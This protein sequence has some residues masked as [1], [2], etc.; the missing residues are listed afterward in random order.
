M[1]KGSLFP[2]RPA[3]YIALILLLPLTSAAQTTPGQFKDGDPLFLTTIKGPG[4]M[5]S[6]IGTLEPIYGVSGKDSTLD[7]RLS[8]LEWS[9]PYRNAI[10]SAED[11]D[12]R[13]L[14][15]QTLYLI[16]DGLGRRVF[17]FNANTS[18]ETW[19]FPPPQSAT[20]PT[21]E[22]YLNKPVD[23]FIYRDIAT[24]YFKV[25]IT[26]QDRNRVI[27]VDKE[28]SKIDWKYGDPLYREG[29]GFNQLR[30]PEDAEK[31]PGTSEYI[32]AD[33]GNNRVIIVDSNTNNILWELG[34]D[35]LKSPVDIQYNNTNNSILITDQGNHRVILVDRTSKSI[36]W[37]FGRTGVADSGAVGL[38]LPTDADLVE[39]TNHVII[40][41]AGNER[42]IEVDQ[43]GR[44][45]WQFHRRLKGLRDVDRIEN[46]RTLTVYENYPARLAYTEA[47]VVSGAYDLGEYHSSVFDSL[48]WKA[49][50]VAG[51]T[52]A[53]FQLRT[54][55]SAFALDGATWFGPNGKD[56][57]YTRSG[58]ALNPVHTGHRWYQFR[59]LLKTKDPLQ[60][61]IIRGVSVVHH[62]YDVYR[63]ESYFFSPIISESAGKLVSQ[64]N[65]LSFKTI[66][67]K[68]VEKRAA[69]DI[70]VRILNAK[71]S[72]ILERFTASKLSESNEITLS[73][74]PALKGIQSIYLVASLSTGNSS[75]TPIMD[76][77]EITWDA[78]PTANSS[79]TFTDR[80]A[81]PKAYYRTTTTLPSTESFVDSVYILLRDPDLEPFRS[82]YRVTVRALGTKDSVKVDLKLLTLGGFFSSKAI[83][84]LINT[85]AVP[86]N[87]IMEAQDRDHL[88]VSYQDSMTAL[89][90][91]QDT[92]LVVKNTTGLMTIENTRK[93]EIAKANFGDTLFV[94]IKNESD[95]NLD[96]DR[97]E[98][99]HVALFDNVTMDREELTL[100]E[101]AS[102][103]RFNSSEFI[104]QTGVPIRHSNNGIRGNGEIETMPG[105]SVAAEY[106]DNLTLTR[107][108]LIPTQ[109]DTSARDSI[110]IFY[111]RKPAGA[112]IGPNPYHADRNGK[113]RLR[114]GFSTDSLAV[115]SIEI[116]NLAGER[117]RTLLPGVDFSFRTENNVSVTNSDLWWDLRN[118]GG[119]E[120][121]SGTYWAKVNAETRGLTSPSRRINYLCKFVIIR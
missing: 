117:V 30:S 19:S 54:A 81:N 14:N 48:F 38:K 36:L 106:V 37:Q 61:A 87:N 46:G 90:A 82:T 20:D 26:D 25:V 8:G 16:T 77:W 28:T 114:V 33:K 23:A 35:V 78:I 67:A 34:S 15:G 101:V 12:S 64:W 105:H 59:A 84:I 89:D 62:Y 4:T 118:D 32:I 45:V 80:N 44:I 17:E 92:I 94:R 74:L 111:G 58:S 95:H 73:S 41:D 56:S 116:F 53:W 10:T 55:E 120:V 29:N 71:N 13:T 49:D 43:T 7:Y 83:P 9:Y 79:I 31:I 24:S 88:V 119:Q 52:S 100:Y 3:L 51:T 65:K 72:Q 66:L 70:E 27:T 22:K 60:T 39:E 85:K 121:S 98:T 99:L 1:K 108:V 50:T 97:Q 42:I 68:E 113:F 6:D 63:T 5:L 11:I 115:S 76:N 69:V 18:V 96:P 91:S 93:L 75:M 2:H 110:Y 107:Y 102:G 104:T 86:D 103:G 47:Y 40:A 112:E 21:D 57:W 109:S